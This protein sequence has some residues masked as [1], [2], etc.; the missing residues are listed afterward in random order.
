[1]ERCMTP[2]TDIIIPVR[3]TRE[4]PVEQTFSECV[5]SICKHT[6]NFRFIF[7]DDNSDEI[8]R[9]AVEQIAARFHSAILIRTNFQ[10]WFTRA[11]NLG[12]RM[13]RSPWVVT[14]NCDTVVDAGWLEELYAVKDDATIGYG[15]VGLVGSVLSEEEPRRYELS[16][17]QDYVTGHGWLLSMDALTKA[18]V[19]RGTPGIY[20]D[21]T[22]ADAIHIRSD[23]FI[24][25][26][27]NGL[28]FNC[29]KSFKSKVGHYGGRSW[30]H[31]V[32]VVQGLR[33]ED[34]S[35]RY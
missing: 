4:F 18:S 25:W 22:R 23:V 2:N 11:I 14:L 35:Y 26:Q 10:H 20:L 34:V 7:V 13:V 5:D 29:V 12:L 8:C 30:G 16:V 19:Q 9:N 33:L 15:Q 3:G 1:M 6:S 24:C 32:G 28:G 17:G 21:E 27:L 31:R